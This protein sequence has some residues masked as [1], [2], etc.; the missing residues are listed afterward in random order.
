VKE[1]KSIISLITTAH[2]FVSAARAG[3]TFY[4]G[5]MAGLRALEKLRN[6]SQ[7]ALIQFL[8]TDLEVAATLLQSATVE[9]YTDPVRVPEVLGKVR[10]TVQTVRHF[11]GRVEDPSVWHDI[12]RRTDEIETQLNHHLIRTGP[13][14]EY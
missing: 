13:Q 6:D 12:H 4:D 11:C 1:N 2:G 5:Q 3:W 14:S 9:A 7:A 8:T 10:E